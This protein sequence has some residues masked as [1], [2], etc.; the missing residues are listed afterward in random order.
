MTLNSLEI[1]RSRI[2]RIE[3]AARQA[4]GPGYEKTHTFSDGTTHLYT[5]AGIKSPEQLEDDL[6][7]LFIWTWSLKDYLKEYYKTKNIDPQ[8]VEVIANKNT[9]L[10]YVA[11]IANRAKHGDLRT[12]R[13]GM[14]AELVDVGWTVPQLA[15]GKISVGSFNVGV[16][17]AKPD[18]VELH[19]FVRLKM[20][21]V[22][23]RFKYFVR[24]LR[25]GKKMCSSG[26]A[27]MGRL[28]SLLT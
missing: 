11:D 8:C 1:L 26:S 17:V 12:S 22:S 16:D 3:L 21:K 5:V 18:H 7:H 13:S 2:R 19:A 27:P 4:D 14:F 24:Q 15:L 20:V 28:P 10:Q 25:R 6:L 23:M 9:A